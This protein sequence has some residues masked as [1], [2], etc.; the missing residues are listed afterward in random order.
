MIRRLSIAVRCISQS[1]E[2]KGFDAVSCV[3]LRSNIQGTRWQCNVFGALLYKDD[4]VD[5]IL[6]CKECMAAERGGSE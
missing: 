6:R 3:H 2:E 5:Q 4:T 1:C